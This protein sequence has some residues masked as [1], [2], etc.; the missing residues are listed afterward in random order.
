MGAGPAGAGE[1]D[2]SGPGPATQADKIILEGQPA[3]GGDHHRAQTLKGHGE[4]PVPNAEGAAERTGR[5]VQI[6]SGPQGL[7][8]AQMGGKVFIPQ[9]EPGQTL[10]GGDH[11]HETP[12]LAGDPP[13]PARIRRLR[14][15]VHHRVQIGGNWQT[16]MLE[17]IA[18]VDRD[19]QLFRR[20]NP[21]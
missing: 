11:R 1:F 12:G 9:I 21:A 4:D 15:R 6:Q 7:G 8:A 16:R 13:A 3:L 20:Q 17:I 14:Q 18:G 5:I 19:K 2:G 10:E